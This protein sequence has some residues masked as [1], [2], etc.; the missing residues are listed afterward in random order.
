MIRDWLH[1]IARG[2]YVSKCMQGRKF[3]CWTCD[4]GWGHHC[5]NAHGGER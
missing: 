5:R 1:W 4:R 2:H 3:W